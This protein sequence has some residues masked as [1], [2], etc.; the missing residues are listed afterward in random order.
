MSN[1]WVKTPQWL[2]KCF[3][4]SIRWDMPEEQEPV[5][6]LT[7][8]DG[9][10]PTITP[11]VLEQL[12]IS[13]SKATFFCVGNNVDQYPEVYQRL[14][15]EG[16]TT[17]NH[18]QDHLNGW[19]TT[20]F[21]YLK[22]IARAATNIENRIFRPPYGR[23]KISQARKLIT[24]KPSWKIYMWDILS[25]DFDKTITAE[26]CTNNVITHLQP[27]SIVVFHDSEKAFDRLRYTLPEVI[28]FCLSK[29][30]KLKSL[31]NNVY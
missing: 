31:P 12:A 24:A 2:K 18:T 26:Q 6:Y 14:L 23:L 29:G 27:G 30:W 11:F 21:T 13:D 16:H 4:Q 17:G 22:N 19:H 5:V 28:K 3:P 1:Y 7:F 25:G 15:Q 20:N 9:P 8:D 10:H